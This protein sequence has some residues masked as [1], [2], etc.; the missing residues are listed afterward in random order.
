MH[1]ISLS[2]MKIRSKL[3]ADPFEAEMLAMAGALVGT[4]ED[5]GSSSEE[6]ANDIEALNNA[7]DRVM[8]GDSDQQL[9]LL[10][11]DFENDIQ[12]GRVLP[13]QLPMAIVE[14]SPQVQQTNSSSGTALFVVFNLYGS[15]ELMISVV[16]TSCS[17]PTVHV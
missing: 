2:L 15:C 5:P 13:K 7:I 4:K 11:R 8:A 16:H 17:L 9:R 1:N 3:P 6:E 12:A 14:P 10:G